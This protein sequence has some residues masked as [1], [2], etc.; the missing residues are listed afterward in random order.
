MP[1]TL[2]R[3]VLSTSQQKMSAS[4]AQIRDT[5]PHAGETGDL[6]ERV[7]RNQLL[8]VLPEKSVSQTASW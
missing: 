4:I 1:P 6:V 8:E 5:V 7:F 2:Y 3:N